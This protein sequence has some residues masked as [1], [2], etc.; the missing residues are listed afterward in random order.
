MQVF[1]LVLCVTFRPTA[2]KEQTSRQ[3]ESYSWQRERREKRLG[4]PYMGKAREAVRIPKLP[5]SWL[6]I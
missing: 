5:W 6:L 1:Y 3:G 4:Q 2:D